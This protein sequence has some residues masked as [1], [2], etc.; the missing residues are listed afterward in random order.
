M[1]GLKIFLLFVA[2]AG[3]LSFGQSARE[4][5][6]PQDYKTI[7]A[8]ITAALPGDTVLVA[9][10][11]YRERL[12]I[13]KPLTLKGEDRDKVLLDGSLVCQESRS[14]IRI[15]ARG[16]RLEALSVA[17]CVIG[18]EVLGS[19][20]LI[21]V[22]LRANALGLVV[23]DLAQASLDDSVLTD[24]SVGVEAWTGARISITDTVISGSSIGAKVL[25]AAWATLARSQV[26]ASTIGIEVWDAR[27]VTIDTSRIAENSSDGIWVRGPTGAQ[28]TIFKSVIVANG[29]N[30]IRLGASPNQPDAVTAE[31]RENVIQN[32]RGCGV[33]VDAEKAITVTG[34]GNQ[35]SGNG[36][37]D[38]CPPTFPWPQGF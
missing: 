17:Q 31:I 38:L 21:N 10:G 6:V 19:A 36:A 37:G 2:V 3:M 12:L 27:Q 13:D 20:D 29:E 35:I 25:R 23:Q 7:Q 18:V 9:A 15:E 33:W 26:V 22:A 28:V 34:S 32:N 4:L 1:R 16:V 14:V 30:G 11:I 8:A 5:K 24:N